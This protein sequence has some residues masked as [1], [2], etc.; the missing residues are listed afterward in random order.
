MLTAGYGVVDTYHIVARG[1][2][3]VNG[4]ISSVNSS[5]NRTLLPYIDRNA[6]AAIGAHPISDNSPTIGMSSDDVPIKS[7]IMHRKSLPI[8]G[9]ASGD[10]LGVDL[11]T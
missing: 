7:I 2:R 9:V 10:L 1:R 8:S 4:K 5:T 11:C 3:S 6:K